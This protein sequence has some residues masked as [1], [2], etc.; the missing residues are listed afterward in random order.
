MSKKQYENTFLNPELVLSRQR[1]QFLRVIS[2]VG[3]IFAI[4]TLLG[5]STTNQLITPLRYA[6]MA[7]LLIN[8]AVTN[9]LLNRRRF[10]TAALVTM[11]I[12]GAFAISQIDPQLRLV[13]SS[14]AVMT[15]SVV[16]RRIYY[17]V[18]LSI[19]QMYFAVDLSEVI[20]QFGFVV[21]DEGLFIVS[22][23]ISLILIA[24]I[25]RFFLF[26]IERTAQVS[27]RTSSLLRATS[28]ISQIT[29]KLLTIDELFNRA[30]TLIQ[31]RFAFYHVQVFM[32]DDRREFANLVA[33][34]GDVGRKL[35][36]R[37]HRLRVGS[38]SV[39]G[40][41]TQIGEPVIA[42]DTDSDRVHAVNELLPNT[43][44]ELA[45]PI[46]DGDVII[47]ALDVQST[48]RN[49]FDSTDVQA[50]Q[51]MANQL[52]VAIRNAR[53]FESQEQALRENKRLFLEGE[54]ERREIQRLNSQ[55][56]R[57]AWEGYLRERPDVHGITAQD[58]KV[59]LNA[60]WSE[61]MIEAS[62]RQRPISR[63]KDERRTIAVP[64]V[65]RNQV[66]GAIEVEIDN[67]SEADKTETIVNVA[68]R[69][70]TTLDNIRLFD[71]AQ[72]ATM[73]EQRINTVVTS[74]QA[75]ENIE[76]LLRITLEELSKTL[77]ADHGM[78]RLGIA[79]ADKSLGSGSSGGSNGSKH[80]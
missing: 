68:Q 60:N 51:V 29:S 53:L 10:D 73:Q 18:T 34:T 54:A 13:A 24:V 72:I 77:A 15:A 14:L 1:I 31:D 40:R 5:F 78:I 39:I 7:A 48:R 43:R 25:F 59:N 47:G 63:V 46:I 28:E 12:F 74:Y 52:G 26:G 42:R 35:L 17:L 62:N 30:V 50:L 9:V 21:V 38:K 56:T 57:A 64:I 33:S 65:L 36:D 6:I 58:D 20:A 37:G 8:F 4:A 19:I 76:D 27:A 32:V 67:R 23:M 79:P 3:A 45:L 22:S 49:A 66:L 80:L 44:S 11:L 70:A 55:L 69:L 61:A 75:A 41:V 71:E 16:G 2:G